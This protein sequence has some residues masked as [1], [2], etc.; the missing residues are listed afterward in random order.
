MSIGSADGFLA[1]KRQVEGQQREFRERLQRRADGI[2]DQRR[3]PREG[4]AEANGE[5]LAC[6]RC[7]RQFAFGDDCPDCEEGLVGLSF[8]GA[9][10]PI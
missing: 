7:R 1:L 9:L 5:P 8:V 10:A 4:E 6:P 3:H 2:F